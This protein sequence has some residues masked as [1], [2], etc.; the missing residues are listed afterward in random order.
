MCAAVRVQ[1]VQRILVLRDNS[2]GYLL[3][4]DATY[5]PKQSYCVRAPLRVAVALSFKAIEA[6]SAR[7]CADCRAL[8]D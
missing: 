4:V 3:P 5:L 8:N 1:G 6:R 2:D 7:Y